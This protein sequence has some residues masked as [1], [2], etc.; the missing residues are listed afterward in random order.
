MSPE[1]GTTLRPR[2]VDALGPEERRRWRLALIGYC[3]LAV[4]VVAALTVAVLQQRNTEQVQ[5]DLIALIA[6]SSYEDCGHRNEL[7][8]KF[9]DPG[10]LE[11][12][13]EIRASY[14]EL[15]PG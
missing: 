8:Q 13:A 10:Q 2:H 6:D 3:I 12:C 7:R 15:L 5:N 11:D 14:R 4:A 9:D 1:E